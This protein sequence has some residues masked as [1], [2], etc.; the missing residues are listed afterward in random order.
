MKGI[1]QQFCSTVSEL[2]DYELNLTVVKGMQ[3]AASITHDDLTRLKTASDE[4]LLAVAEGIV[5]EF[6][7]RVRE[8]SDLSRSLADALILEEELPY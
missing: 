1:V 2:S 7:R 4:S 6:E 5:A 3:E 8:Q